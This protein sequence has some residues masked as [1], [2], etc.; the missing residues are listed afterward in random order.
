M[1]FLA[2]ILD[3]IVNDD[4]AMLLIVALVLEVVYYNA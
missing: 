3:V 4:W 1:R 2:M